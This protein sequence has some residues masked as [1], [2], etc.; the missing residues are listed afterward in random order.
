MAATLRTYKPDGEAIRRLR[1]AKGLN[2]EEFATKAELSVGT[3]R[4]LEK[5]APA[6]LVTLR[7]CADALGVAC[8]QIMAGSKVPNRP[9]NF[10]LALTIFI[11]FRNLDQTEQ[12]ISLLTELIRIAGLQLEIDVIGIWPT[13]SVRV[14][15]DLLPK[16]YLRLLDF[17][18][19]SNDWIKLLG[20]DVHHPSPQLPDAEA[21]IYDL[22][23]DDSA[24][25]AEE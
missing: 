1:E 24:D 12:L 4:N 9:L 17:F 23:D 3:I 2:V 18:K 15:L 21:S 13:Q 22:P 19:Q 25:S 6:F 8:D 14:M 7:Q 16:D 10:P 20:V 5:G 11:E